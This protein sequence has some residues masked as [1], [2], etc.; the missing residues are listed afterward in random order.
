M[1]EPGALSLLPKRL[2]NEGSLRQLL[3]RKSA[4]VVVTEAARA[5]FIAGLAEISKIPAAI[6]AI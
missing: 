4:E 3:G 5:F 2:A 1:K 6:I